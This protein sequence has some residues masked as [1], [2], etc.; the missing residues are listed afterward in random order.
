LATIGRAAVERHAETEAILAYEHALPLAEAAVAEAAAAGGDGPDE[1]L[2]RFLG[3]VHDV[4]GGLKL[5]RSDLDGAGHHFTMAL[6]FSQELDP[7]STDVA[8]FTSNLGSVA[9]HRGDL[10]EALRLYRAAADLAARHTPVPDAVGTYLSNAGTILLAQ[11]DL[12]GALDLFRRALEIDERTDPAAAATDLSLIGSVFLESGEASQAREHFARALAVHRRLDPRSSDT[13]RDLVNLGYCH[14]L[15]GD[16]DQALQHYYAALDTDRALGPESLEVAGDL[17]NISQVYELRGNLGRAQD[18]LEQALQIS[19]DAAPRSQRTATQLN[20]LGSMRLTAGRYPE[21]RAALEEAL[22]IDQAVAPRSP[23]T[24][25]DLGNLGMIAVRERNLDMAEDYCRRALDLYRALGT[26]TESVAAVLTT[27]SI[28]AYQRGDK[29]GAMA[30]TRAAYE[31]D[32]RQV[33]DADPTVT[34]LTNLAFLHAE[35][36]ELD[37]AIARYSEAADIAESLRRLAGTAAARE[38]RFTLL[39]SP[40]QGLVRALFQRGA[41]GDAARAFDVAERARGRVLADLLARGRLD[42][43]PDDDTQRSLLSRERQ[44]EHELAAIDR[45]ADPRR[46]HPVAERLERLR[47]EMRTAFPAYANLREPQPLG[48]AAAQRLL[49]SDTILLCYHVGAQ[50]SAVWAVRADDWAAD[51]L[52][53][54]RSLL[55]RRVDAALAS[56]R[57]EQ[58]E[59]PETLAAWQR[60]SHLLLGAVPAG[61]LSA[62]ARVIVVADGP[63]LYLPFELLRHGDGYLADT[64]VLSYAP[65]ITVLGDLAER[66]TQSPAGRPFLGISLT[67]AGSGDGFSSLPGAREVL[68]IAEDY[69]PGAGV[70]TGPEATKDLIL[71]ETSG[72]RVVHFATHGVLDDAEPLYSGLRVAAGRRSAGEEGADILHVYEMFSLHLAA[73][74]VVCSACQTARGKIRAGEGLVG[75]SRALFYAGASSLVVTLWPI[76][77]V[78]TRRLM[79]VFHRHLRSGHDPAQALARAKQDVRSSHPHVYRHPYTWA[80]FIV[81]GPA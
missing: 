41:D 38:E 61:W 68:E 19:R 66:V 62:A 24:A 39:Q 17:N 32:R 35:S 78:P 26:D 21:A 13:A 81:L 54:S 70:V 31:I 51:E 72:Y 11:G 1:D 79:R 16:L 5:A 63:L 42:L 50:G 2:A 52:P 74:V 77:D 15:T 22:R 47:M 18:Y 65:S 4:L 12:T 55:E 48:L 75:M 20:N 8:K 58:P 44:L 30:H 25:R 3:Y 71:K 7:A 67:G 43:D 64:L 40:Y 80:G 28:V 59:G 56:C 6:K 9:R 69:G 29:K 14:R 76:P 73:A 37:E 34:D 33:P 27:L 53:A 57:A 49:R 23:D 45:G 36:G 46:R 10:E 60:L